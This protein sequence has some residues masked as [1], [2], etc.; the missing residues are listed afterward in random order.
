MKKGLL[1]LAILIAAITVQAQ[2]VRLGVSGGL[3][4]T[5]LMNKNVFDQDD[6]LDIAASFGGRFGIDA[7]YSF[8]EKAGVSIGFNFLSTHNQ[9]YTGDETGLNGDLTTKL[10]YLDIPILF[11]LTSSSGTYFELG[12]QFGILGS[13]KENYESDGGSLFNIEY[14][15]KNVKSGFNSTNIALLLVFGK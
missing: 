2:N 3:N 7:I 9:K 12:P 8:S 13:A 6:G 14:E 1:T 4:S 15:N 10:N 5:W 11:R